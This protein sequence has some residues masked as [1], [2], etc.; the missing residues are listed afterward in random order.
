MTERSSALVQQEMKFT[1]QDLETAPSALPALR[2]DTDTTISASNASPARSTYVIDFLDVGDR[3]PP[4]FEECS[5]EA[6]INRKANKAA[7][8]LASADWIDRLE[9]SL[10]SLLSA[11]T[12][13]YLLLWFISR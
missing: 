3:L 13:V 1:Q 9:E 4:G 5:K 7:H 2:I 8:R 12:L 10:Y 11:A 6:E